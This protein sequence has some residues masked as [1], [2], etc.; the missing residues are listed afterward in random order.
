MLKSKVI[1]DE[2][3]LTLKSKVI[4]DEMKFN[5]NLFL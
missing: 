3:K 1:K 4:K 2:M 5:S